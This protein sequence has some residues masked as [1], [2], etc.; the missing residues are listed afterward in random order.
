MI[1]ERKQRDDYVYHSPIK[2]INSDDNAE[3]YLN[4]NSPNTGIKE[5]MRPP[6]FD[7]KKR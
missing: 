5:L 1:L 6:Q 2:H 3:K 4:S 7:H